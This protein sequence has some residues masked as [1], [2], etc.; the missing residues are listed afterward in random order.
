MM[1]FL[2]VFSVFFFQLPRGVGDTPRFAP[3]S[4][5]ASSRP[6]RA[7]A[8]LA[9]PRSGEG[10]MLRRSLLPALSLLVNGPVNIS[11]L[12]FYVQIIYARSTSI[13]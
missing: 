6:R 11:L 13:I 4:G 10:D 9:P 8:P 7:L 12:A 3:L 1:Y 2:P 5:G